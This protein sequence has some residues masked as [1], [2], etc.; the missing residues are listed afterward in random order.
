MHL[1]SRRKWQKERIQGKERSGEK[2]RDFI[3]EG[4]ISYEKN[5]I[6]NK[7]G[8]DWRVWNRGMT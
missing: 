5:F 6:L 3:K 4:F 8:S 1:K 7:V 2:S